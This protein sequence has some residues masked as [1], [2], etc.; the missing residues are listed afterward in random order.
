MSFL[1]QISPQ[2]IPEL[3]QFHLTELTID[4]NY[5]RPISQAHVERLVRHF[6]PSLLGVITVS[7]RADGTQAVV[8]GQ[9]R[10]MACVRKNY[11]PI[12]GY[13][14]VGLTPEK[15]A[16]LFAVYNR[17][18]KQC[19]AKDIFKARWYGGDPEAIHIQDIANDCGITLGSYT[20]VSG[21][22]SQVTMAY[23]A[24]ETVYKDFGAYI[25]RLTFQFCTRAWP[26]D[27]NGIVSDMILGV[28]R[29]LVTYH[30]DVDWE[31]VADKLKSISPIVIR[32]DASTVSGIL[33]GTK[34]TRQ[35]GFQIAYAMVS[36]YNR[37]K[38]EENRL[39]DLKLQ[40]PPTKLL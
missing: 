7:I 25:L 1:Q 10:V 36:R 40:V 26:N 28:A 12:W 22:Q 17:A 6:K 27:P 39:S 2:E 15:E 38:H 20:P 5:Q 32:R 11:S 8:D 31:T 13:P 16:E 30:N 23:R 35:G 21:A 4:R 24:V 3:R 18:R 33:L 34:N 37:G 9:H 29:F 19:T 14:Y